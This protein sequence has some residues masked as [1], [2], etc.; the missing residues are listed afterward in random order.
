MK[1]LVLYS[2]TFYKD[3]KFNKTLLDSIKNLE[4]VVIHNLNAT[5][6]NN[7]INIDNEVKLLKDANKIIAQF[8]LFWFSSPSMFKEWQDTVLT[9]IYHSS[10]PK[11]LDG[12]NFQVITTA[13]GIKSNYDKW[14]ENNN[15]GLERALFPIYKTFEHVGAK[16]IKPFVIYDIRNTNLPLDDYMKCFTK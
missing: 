12:K 8:P 4:N 13:G 3:S 5:Y 9:H 16:S 1:T 14:D 11:M 6:S 2:H 10:N 7:N 15:S